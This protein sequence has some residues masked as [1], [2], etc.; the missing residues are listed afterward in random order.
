[1]IGSQQGE[2]FR[3][4][5][6]RDRPD[7]QIVTLDAF[8]RHADLEHLRPMLKSITLEKLAY[9]VVVSRPKALQTL[10][11]LGVGSVT[12]R[13]RLASE[14][15]KAMREGTVSD[16]KKAEL[17]AQERESEATAR[18]LMAKQAA[19]GK[20]GR[21]Q[22]FDGEIDLASVMASGASQEDP[23]KRVVFKT[24]EDNMTATAL[25]DSLSDQM[26]SKLAQLATLGVKEA[27][28]PS[29]TKAVIVGAGLAGMAVATELVDVCGLKEMVLVERSH[30]AGGVWCHQANSYSRVNSSEP[31]YRLLRN[32]VPPKKETLTNHTPSHQIVDSMVRLIAQYDLAG[33]LFTHSTVASVLPRKDGRKGWLVEGNKEQR[34]FAINSE[35]V[36]MCTN[37]RLGTPRDITYKGEADF[38]GVIARGLNSD[39]EALSWKDRVVII[40]MGAFA[41]E[42]MRTALERGAPYC[43]ILCRRRGAVCPQV[44]DWVNFVRP[45][46]PDFTKDVAGSSAVFTLWAKA[47]E[48]SQA[49]VPDCWNERPRMLKP[50]GHTVSTSDLFFVAHHLKMAATYLGEIETFVPD[51][52]FTQGH[53]EIPNTLMPCGVVIKC[54]GF[55]TNKANE[56][57]L[58][59]KETR[60][61]GLVDDNLWVVLEAH[62]DAGFFSLPFGS[63]YAA[64]AAYTASCIA[65]GFA[66]P[67]A[68]RK[69]LATPVSS[70][71]SPPAAGML[72]HALSLHAIP[73]PTPRRSTRRSRTSLPATSST[74]LSLSRRRCPRWA[75]CC[76]TTLRRRPNA[77]M[78]PS[79]SARTSIATR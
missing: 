29:E 61:S 34:P 16:P 27:L 32:G 43:S 14:L 11:D 2:D 74:R 51:G 75:S 19:A 54:V 28:P 21:V 1:M 8:L 7:M 64:Q 5:C 77:S 79:T 9:Q 44:I 25:V 46:H 12:E 72:A 30:S 26:A 60:A 52:I 10:K 31:S 59:R 56:T 58:Q 63:S 39:A 68:M 69:M 67:E 55:L 4:R 33:K 35:L 3:K 66:E 13:Q 23:S 15:S 65:K 42:H 45:V 47:Y 50:D 78:A 48:L 49:K 53:G 73:P 18:L 76:T 24:Y 41:L 71:I 36:A 37:R 22:K 40:G 70:T 57:I 17:E 20:G 38:K 62:L 6:G